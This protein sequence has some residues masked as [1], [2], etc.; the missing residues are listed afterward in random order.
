MPY[1]TGVA[2][3]LGAIVTA[4]R[5]ACVANGWTLA[6]NVLHKGG[7]YVEILHVPKGAHIDHGL[8]QIRAG[9][10]IDGANAL[11]DAATG[12]DGRYGCGAIGPMGDGRSSTAYTDWAWPV[13]YHIHI[14]AEPDEVFLM[15]NYD[16]G[17]YWQGLSFGRSPVPGCPGTG[18]WYHAS[19]PRAATDA[20]TAGRLTGAA[21][22]VVNPGGSDLSTWSG[23]TVPGAIPFWGR[24]MDQSGAVP[25]PGQF[26]GTWMAD[27]ETVGWS[28]Q[29]YYWNSSPAP[30]INVVSAAL[31][32]QPLP[33]YSPNAWN[34]E[35]H[36][37]RLQILT[38]RLE[39]KSSLVGEIRHAR[40]IRNDF[41]DDGTVVTLGPDRWKVYPAYRKNA[42]VR[43]GPGPAGDTHSGTC[44]I[45]IRYDGP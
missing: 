23:G 12:F 7:C 31:T 19:A 9:N 16:S 38:P 39:F 37:I 25:N 2:T 27:G 17:R 6:G 21:T 22:V 10:G 5:N 28:N 33:A 30:A 1:V 36:L 15:V 45:A 42:A 11:V 13:T 24:A 3:S 44:A 34:N 32:A 43:N 18:N 40:F 8:I 35:A 14:L 26:H 41:L 29:R 20:G 4:L